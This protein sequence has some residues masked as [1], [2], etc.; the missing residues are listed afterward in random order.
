MGI[1]VVVLK[2]NNQSGGNRLGHYNSG[3]EAEKSKSGGIEANNQSGGNQMDNYNICTEA[4]QSKRHYSSCTEIEQSKRWEPNGP[5]QSKLWAIAV[6]VL[7][8]SNQSGRK[9]EQSKRAIK[10]MGHY[11]SGIE[12]EQSKR[13]DLNGILQ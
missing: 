11:S 1:I 2:H 3:T 10:A 5:E 4:K 13:W 6:V 8:Q 9:V 12:A 7:K